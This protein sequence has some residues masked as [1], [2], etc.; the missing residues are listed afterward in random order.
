MF[1]MRVRLSL[2][3][4]QKAWR[5]VFQKSMKVIITTK[6]LKII[7]SKVYVDKESRP[8]IDVRINHTH[9]LDDPFED[10]DNLVVPS[11]SPSPDAERIFGAGTRVGADELLDEDDGLTEAEQK[12]PFL[13]EISK[14][15]SSLSGTRCNR[16][17]RT[18]SKCP[19]N[20][21][22]SAQRR[23]GA[24]QERAVCLQTEPNH[25]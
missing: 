15:I 5:S 2:A 6:I 8:K 17:S 21:R 7:S 3:K 11:R 16:N 19:H 14:N 9:I 22:R 24:G 4:S 23:R 10:P 1:L 18:S 12:V 25:N 20:C 13:P